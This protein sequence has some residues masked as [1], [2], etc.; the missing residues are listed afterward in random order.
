MLALG[1]KWYRW[2]NEPSPDG[3]IIGTYEGAYPGRYGVYRPTQDSLMRTLGKP[4]NMVGMEALV[5]AFYQ[6]V[7]PIDAS[8]PTDQ[9]LPGTGSVFVTPMQPA[10]HNLNITWYLNGQSI[11]ANQDQT[12]F[13]VSNL[14]LSCAAT[15]TVS[16]VVVDNTAMV[17]D[18]AARA[19]FLTDRRDWIVLCHETYLPAVAR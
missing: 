16:A 17:R 11:P 1:T 9:A 19:Q 18:P 3:G 15:H 10:G 12:T 2:L 14:P 5:I 7:R 13:D 4:Y 6:Q 8:T